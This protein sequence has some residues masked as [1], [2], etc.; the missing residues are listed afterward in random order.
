MEEKPLLDSNQE[1]DTVVLN[2]PD[3][4]QCQIQDQSDESSGSMLSLDKLMDFVVSTGFWILKVS[5]R[6]IGLLVATYSARIIE[7]NLPK[8]K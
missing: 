2:P 7:N 8:K 6:Y 3:N 5:C 4:L 1:T